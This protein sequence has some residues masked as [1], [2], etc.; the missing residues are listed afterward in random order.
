[1]FQKDSNYY[2][3]NFKLI[4]GRNFHIEH[5]WKFKSLIDFLLA[6]VSL[7]ILRLNKPLVFIYEFAKSFLRNKN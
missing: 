5:K 6:M 2:H 7:K 4:T 3:Q 1:L